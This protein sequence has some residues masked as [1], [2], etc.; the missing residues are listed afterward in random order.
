MQECQVSIATIKDINIQ[1]MR[2]WHK[3]DHAL[4]QM[5]AVAGAEHKVLD[6]SQAGVEYQ[7]NHTVTVVA[8]AVLAAAAWFMLF[9]IKGK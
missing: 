6:T 4:V 2:Q 7:H 8:Q 5:V 3:V 9:I 1:E